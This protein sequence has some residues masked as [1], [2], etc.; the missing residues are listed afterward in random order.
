MLLV[1]TFQRATSSL[2]LIEKLVKIQWEGMGPCNANNGLHTGP[3]EAKKKRAAGITLQSDATTP[4]NLRGDLAAPIILQQ[5]NIV[6][7][8][9]P[10]GTWPPEHS[11]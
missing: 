4:I 10:P 11:P 9:P 5:R 3:T 2:F 7:L 1:Y 6:G 8:G